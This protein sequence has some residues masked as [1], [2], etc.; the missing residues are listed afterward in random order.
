MSALAGFSFVGQIR[1]DKLLDLIQATV[2]VQGKSLIT[3]FRLS[4]QGP[5][6]GLPPRRLNTVDLLVKSLDL[7]LDIGT[8]RCILILRLEGGVIR[9]PGTPEAPFRNGTLNVKLLLVDGTFIVT[10]PIEATLDAPA[11]DVIAAIPDFTARANIEV[12]KLIDAE[13]NVDV[14]LYPDAGYAKIFSIFSHNRNLDAQTFCAH[15]GKGNADN[16]TATVDAK[17]SVSFAISADTIIASL[18]TAEALSVPHVT[19]TK[20]NYSFRD[21]LIEIDGEFDGDDTCW[22]IDGGTIHQLI[23]PSLTGSNILFTP[24][25]PQP[26]LSFKLRIA[27]LC[28]VGLAA[29]EFL[30]V[31]LTP[32]F[33][34]FMRLNLAHTLGVKAHFTVPATPAQTQPGFELGGVTWAQLVISPEGAVLLGNRLG[35]GIVTAVQNPAVHIRTNDDPLP[36]NAVPGSATVQG[37]TCQPQ[38]FDYVELIQDDRNTLTVDSDWMFEPIDYAWAINGVPLVPS[39]ELTVLGGDG[40]TALDFNGT[41]ESPLPA[42]NGTAIP[43]HAITLMYRA[44]GRTLLLNARHGDLNYDIRV[45]LRATDALGRVLSDAVNLTMTGDVVQFGQDYEDYMDA[46]VKAATAR[47]NDKGRK[48]RPPKPGE[49]RENWRDLMDLVAVQ[50]RAGDPEAHALLPGLMRAVGVRVVAKAMAGKLIT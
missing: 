34:D 26:D 21:V 33:L 15:L 13:R 40:M 24:I 45:E 5:P 46:C 30:D 7:S 25:P 35:G 44:A 28:E 48:Q 12:N 23:F 29:I 42:P 6:S 16:L 36:V 1:R 17:N 22:S 47:V 31:A 49:P 10:R 18:P 9:L 50:L 4:I 11:T 19:I 37:P 43:E 14:D 3:P 39:S 8:N 27:F 2:T 38:L 32:P 20:L 41:V